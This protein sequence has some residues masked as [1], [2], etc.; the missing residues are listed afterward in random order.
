MRSS[1]TTPPTHPPQNASQRLP[2]SSSPPRHQSKFI[3]S[4]SLPRRQPLPHRSGPQYRSRSLPTISLRLPSR[5]HITLQ[6]PVN[7]RLIPL[8]GGSEVI[9]NRA[10]YAHRNPLGA[11]RLYKLGIPPERL[12]QL[13]NITEVDVVVRPRRDLRHRQGFF[14]TSHNRLALCPIPATIRQS[15]IPLKQND[16]QTKRRALFPLFS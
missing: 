14:D 4:C 2:S 3:A 9:Q 6:H 8:S 5:T 10:L 13:R 11:T 1:Q 7:P 12:I 15:G 16:D